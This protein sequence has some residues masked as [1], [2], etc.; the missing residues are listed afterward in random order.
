MQS[1]VA[2]AG[3]AESHIKVSHVTRTRHAHQ[4]TAC[5][6]YILLKKVLRS[7]QGVTRSR[8]SSSG[9][10]RLVYTKARD[11]TISVLVHSRTAGASCLNINYVRSLREG[12]FA[13]YID[14]LTKLAPWF[15]SF[16]HTNYA[17]W[18][19][20][21]IRDMVKLCKVH[22]EIH[23]SQDKPTIFIYGT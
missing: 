5:S 7:V 20:V 9:I 13:L 10:Y 21:H 11:T 15:F 8:R 18:V 6:L 4:V 22:P 17:R 12:N 3:T 14:S 2:S 19:P 16:D 23:S 1:K